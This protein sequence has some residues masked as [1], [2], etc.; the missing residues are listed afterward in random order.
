MT[1]CMQSSVFTEIQFKS[2][3][4]NIYNNI[5]HGRW[6]SLNSVTYI[7]DDSLNFHGFWS[8]LQQL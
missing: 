8:V 2:V 4:L 3:I 6:L 7:T 5:V 1:N